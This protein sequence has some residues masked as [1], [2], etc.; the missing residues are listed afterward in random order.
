[1]FIVEKSD[2][3]HMICIKFEIKFKDVDDKF[4]TNLHSFYKNLNKFFTMKQHGT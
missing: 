2:A 3:F 1:M 4:Q